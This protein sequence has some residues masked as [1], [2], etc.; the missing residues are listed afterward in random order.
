MNYDIY[1]SYLWNIDPYY[2]IGSNMI[3]V[4]RIGQMTFK[5]MNF[6]KCFVHWV[7]SK[8]FIHFSKVLDINTGILYYN[9]HNP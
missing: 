8:N 2:K 9:C 1:L 3:K 6:K 5:L 4:F 7:H